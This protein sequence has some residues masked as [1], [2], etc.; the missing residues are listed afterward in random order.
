MTLD[1][2]VYTSRS[3]NGHPVWCSCVLFCYNVQGDIKCSCHKH[4]FKYSA[5]I[6]VYNVYIIL[7]IM[8]IF[9]LTNGL[10]VIIITIKTMSVI[11]IVI[12]TYNFR[13]FIS[14]I[15][16]ISYMHSPHFSISIQF[17]I[18]F[19]Y[20]D[21]YLLHSIY[22]YIYNNEL[23]RWML[24]WSRTIANYHHHQVPLTDH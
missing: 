16:Y 3:E 8:I 20:C 10:I 11:I 1:N 17:W 18:L 23:N 4:T 2:C 7:Y 6:F 22:I 5:L 24:W 14:Y 19:S 15:S 21:I 12:Y 9:L 13:H